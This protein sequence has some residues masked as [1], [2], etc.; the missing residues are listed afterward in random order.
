M[1]VRTISKLIAEHLG[2]E[3]PTEENHG[4][5]TES[6]PAGSAVSGR[7]LAL[8][9]AF[10]KAPR[11]FQALRPSDRTPPL[12]PPSLIVDLIRSRE[13]S[14][15]P[16]QR[17]TALP[18]QSIV[19]LNARP[20]GIEITNEYDATYRRGL[21]AVRDL[22]ALLES[23][24]ASPDPAEMAGLLE[25]AAGLAE[26]YGK[27]AE[28]VHR[29]H[30]RD[31][32]NEYATIEAWL[33]SLYDAARRHAEAGRPAQETIRLEGIMLGF[34][35]AGVNKH[36][37]T[38]RTGTAVKLLIN[39]TARDVAAEWGGG[40]RGLGLWG[41]NTVI[42]GVPEGRVEEFH[43]EVEGRV[44]DFLKHDQALPEEISRQLGGKDVRTSDL[45]G[46]RWLLRSRSHLGLSAGHR[47]LDLRV[48]DV[49]PG[50]A[51]L[52]LIALLEGLAGTESAARGKG[53][54]AKGGAVDFARPAGARP[55]PLLRTPARLA[56]GTAPRDVPAMEAPERGA[57]RTPLALADIEA[58]RLPR[59]AHETGHLIRQRIDLDGYLAQ[60]AREASSGNGD[61]ARDRIREAIGFL[62]N[63]EARPPES[64]PRSIAGFL[65]DGYAR[66]LEQH[67]FPG[68]FRLELFPQIVER[69]FQ[70]ER[71]FIQMAEYRDYWG[72]NREHAADPGDSMHRLTMDILARGYEYHGVE[73]LTGTQG[74]DE[75]YFA[76]RG[77]TSEGAE[78]TDADVARISDHLA[79]HF[80]RIFQNVE[81]HMVVKVPALTGGLYDGRP[82]VIQDGSV[83]VQGEPLTDAAR[84]DLSEVIRMAHG[85]EIEP[86]RISRVESI[87][88]V[89]QVE[90]WNVWSRVDAATGRVIDITL[91]LDATPPEGFFQRII[92]LS[93]TITPAVEIPTGSS[94]EV[95]R[96]AMD[97]AGKI[98]DDMKAAGVDRP[99]ANASDAAPPPVVRLGWLER[100]QTSRP[101]RHA[102]HG[103][104]FAV[105]DAV[106]DL[107]LGEGG[108]WAHLDTYG[109]LARTYL[110]LSLGTAAGETASR[111][112]VAL[113]DNRLLVRQGEAVTLNRAAFRAE[114]AGA[115]GFAIK[116]G[117]LLGAI[118]A[119]EILGSGRIRL[120]ETAWTGGSMLTAMGTSRVALAGAAGTAELAGF[121]RLARGLKTPHPVTMAASV[122]LECLVIKGIGHWRR[123][124]ATAEAG[125]GARDALARAMHA[126][127]ETIARGDV[128]ESRGDVRNVTEAFGDLLLF[129]FSQI[130][131][132]GRAFV[133]AQSEAAE[134]AETLDGLLERHPEAWARIQ[135][136]RE[137]PAADDGEEARLIADLVEHEDARESLYSLTGGRGIGQSGARDLQEA[138]ERRDEARAALQSA[139]IRFQEAVQE[140]LQRAPRDPAVSMP[141]GGSISWHY[142]ASLERD[143]VALYN[144]FQNYLASRIAMADQVQAGQGADLTGRFPGLISGAKSP[145]EH[146]V[147]VSVPQIPPMDFDPTLR[148]P[149]TGAPTDPILDLLGL[150]AME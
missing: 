29:V 46:R 145:V 107:M 18:P 33:G 87:S 117:G 104:V 83:H 32:L 147:D 21:E 6:S 22:R 139:E 37:A 40:A 57:P 101:G 34:N 61:G 108:R 10:F 148:L 121:A 39:G 7:W 100:M 13:L 49:R 53:G 132:E 140:A 55:A 90:R 114:H 44:Y 82:Y 105:G 84:S 72:H 113:F 146:G 131:P 136:I 85:I 142:R 98:A 30:T 134:T 120:E 77:T 123:T 64:L 149:S 118:L 128:L 23:A 110:G 51:D 20:G 89:A 58:G 26:D 17:Q 144:Q 115:K 130:L 28:M 93:T 129:Q 125:D 3:G 8:G 38:Y 116:G 31:G 143:P 36:D 119:T 24:G 16:D 112:A 76:V 124:R 19:T 79:T 14:L 65:S 137:D 45:P 63:P 92:P 52:R 80:N 78:L 111:G 81:H 4:S 47:S 9:Q 109:H 12:L 67:R 106:S 35:L 25:D 150:P 97:R 1:I 95:I 59:P 74:G 48:S 73:V 133:E 43:R 70:G 86:C 5:M 62:D 41:T 42:G 94:P 135:D 68:V 88:S 60:A 71:F 2:N 126:L 96:L 99:Q 54:I 27:A 56:P 69:A 138:T 66:S 11:L 103:G 102:V 15:P 75:V 91:P 141:I 50:D 127:D 122:V